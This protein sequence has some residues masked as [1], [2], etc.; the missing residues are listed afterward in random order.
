ME[1]YY[2]VRCNKA[3]V[4]AGNIKEWNGREVIMTDVR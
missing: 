3:G 1:G 2:I 4:F